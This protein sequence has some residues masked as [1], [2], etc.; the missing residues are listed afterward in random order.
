ML[1]K[2]K[3]LSRSEFSRFFASGVR[4]NSPSLQIIYVPDAEQ[5]AAVVVGKKIYKKAVARNRL[6]RQLYHVVRDWFT[7]THQTGVYIIITK[8]PIRNLS[9]REQSRELVSLLESCR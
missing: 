2:R 4:R 3:R 6:R 1:P 9:S 8:P 7:A 5:R